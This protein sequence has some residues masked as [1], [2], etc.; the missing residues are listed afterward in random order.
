M[1]VNYPLKNP[2]P[3]AS[4][5]LLFRGKNDGPPSLPSNT[6]LFNPVVHIVL[7]PDQSGSTGPREL[8]GEAMRE[9]GKT[10]GR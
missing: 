3:P 6:V 9:T 1:E 5:L 4:R 10:L 7:V 8:L 2:F